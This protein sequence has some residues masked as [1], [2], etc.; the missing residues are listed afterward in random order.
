M[1]PLT[2]K[3]MMGETSHQETISSIRPALSVPRASPRPAMA[4]TAVIDVEAG[5]PATFERK[6]AKPMK[7]RTTM[8][9]SGEKE[10]ATR[11]L[12]RLRTTA[13]PTMRPPAR[14][15]TVISAAAD[16]FERVLLPTAGPK[17]TPVEEPPMLNP[18]K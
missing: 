6:S 16:S 2:Q 18:T 14:A 11:S 17:A 4:P 15:K 13:G 5:T 12:P 9:I 1:T 7:K 8:L 3:A 10:V